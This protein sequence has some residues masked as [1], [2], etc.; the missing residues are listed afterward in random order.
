MSVELS[1]EY[2][3]PRAVIYASAMSDEVQKA[4]DLLGM[5]E[6]PIIGQKEENSFAV[7][8]PEEI[9]LARVEGGK[10]FIYTEKEKYLCRKRLYEALEQ[11][12]GGFMQISKQSAVNLT[13]IKSV[14]AG[15]GGALLLRLKNGASDYVSRKY[16]PG[17]K[18]YLGL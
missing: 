13:E 2:A 10:T 1:E 14:E 3:A 4:I 17:L 9:Y 6:A 16:L 5:S 15:F 11:L 12:G 18:K 8:R 7:I